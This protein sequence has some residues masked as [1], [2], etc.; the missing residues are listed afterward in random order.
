MSLIKRKLGLFDFERYTHLL[1]PRG[2]K[3]GITEILT[4]IN[5]RACLV[6]WK[7]LTTDISKGAASGNWEQNLITDGAQTWPKRSL[8]GSM[9]L[10]RATDWQVIG[11]D[12]KEPI[13]GRRSA[14]P[15]GGA[16]I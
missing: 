7:V 9:Q 8:A 5:V 11:I 10:K 4:P 2:R 1:Y 6:K 13:G 3:L 15:I 12:E 14:S 16:R